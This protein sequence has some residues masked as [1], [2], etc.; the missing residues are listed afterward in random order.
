MARRGSALVRGVHG[1][2]ED[3]PRP[4]R[5]DH[6][7][8]PVVQFGGAARAMAADA[9]TGDDGPARAAAID[10]EEAA[11]GVKDFEVPGGDMVR[12]RVGKLAEKQIVQRHSVPAPEVLGHR[13]AGLGRTALAAHADRKGTDRDLR[14]PAECMDGFVCQRD[15]ARDR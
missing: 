1:E 8:V 12:S 4:G 15:Q 14:D 11:V 10:E 2:A 13:G 5:A 3:V 7:L 6:D 9:R